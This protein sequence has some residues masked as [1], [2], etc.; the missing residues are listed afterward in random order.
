ML[1]K[2]IWASFQRIIEL[3]TQKFVTRL[4]K[5]WV[6]DPGSGKNLYRIPDPGP[7]V[8]KAPDPPRS[9]SAKQ[10]KISISFK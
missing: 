7:G 4:S 3:F 5:I 10:T 1:K 8:K 2:K 9:G 6:W